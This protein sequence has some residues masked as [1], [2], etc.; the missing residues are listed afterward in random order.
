MYSLT[1]SRRFFL[2]LA[3]AALASCVLAARGSAQTLTTLRVMQWNIHNTRGS[4]GICNPDRIANHIVAQTPHVVSLNEVKALAGECSWNF[5]MSVH[6]QSLL[7]S[8]TGVTWYRTFVLIAGTGNVL[9]SRYQPVSSST[10]LLSNNRGVAQITLAVNGVHVNLFTTHVD[11]DNA[12]WR[13]VQIEEAL[14]WIGTFAAPRIVMG[15][16]NTSP[17][18]SDYLLVATPYQDSW[19]AAQS[20]GTATAYNG[21]GATRGTSRLDYVFYS[22]VA[23]FSIKSVNVP[24]TRANGV[25]PS[26]HD[27]VV[28]VFTWTG[29]PLPP[30]GLRVVQ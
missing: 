23:P 29:G 12:S 24:D 30:T 16:F 14:K 10:T 7:Q 26:D 25:Y 4:D 15:D 1:P 9:L 11:F 6:L 5:D 2:W 22:R 21:S 3:G 13:T 19:V 20:A 18:T 8:K 17:G 27:P 28:A